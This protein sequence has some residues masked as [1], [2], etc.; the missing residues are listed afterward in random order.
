MDC[1]IIDVSNKQIKKD[2]PKNKGEKI[3]IKALLHMLTFNKEENLKRIFDIKYILY[4][5][6]KIEELRT[7]PEIVKQCKKCQGFGHTK[8]YCH[9]K[10]VCV[11][12]AGNHSSDKCP[13]GKNITPKCANCKLT[14]HVD[15]YRDCPIARKAQQARDNLLKA[16]KIK[17]RKQENAIAKAQI[18]AGIETTDPV[19]QTSKQQYIPEGKLHMRK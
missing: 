5:K 2:N 11:K 16:R 14:G 4:T 13:R 17:N 19:E 12:C 9:G 6:I 18:R 10:D 8:N 15:S 3:K 7:K 1:K